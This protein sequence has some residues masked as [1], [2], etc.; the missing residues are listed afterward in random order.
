MFDVA[1]QK[2]NGIDIMVNNAGI[3]DERHWE[4]MVDINLVSEVLL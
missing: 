3:S 1:I 4:T 2:Y